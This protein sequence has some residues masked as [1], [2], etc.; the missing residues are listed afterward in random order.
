M[1]GKGKERK[2][3]KEKRVR[4]SKKYKIYVEL[5]CLEKSDRLTDRWAERQMSRQ[6]DGQKDV[7]ER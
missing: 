7:R 2:S 6:T 5:H 3:E 1:R 4:E